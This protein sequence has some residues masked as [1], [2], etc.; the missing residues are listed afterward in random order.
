M[1]QVV[2]VVRTEPAY[3]KDPPFDPSEGYPE[4]S[5]LSVSSSRNVVFEAVRD[6]LRLAG[7]DEDRFGAADW[8]PLGE[9]I[10]PG[11]TVLLK[12]NWVHHSHPRDPE[13]WV[14]TITHGS[15][16]RAVAEYVAKALAGSGRIIVGDAPQTDASFSAIVE[17]TGVGRVAELF[18]T[19]GVRFDVIDFRREQWTESGGVIVKREPLAGDPEGCVKFDL[20]GASRF[21]GHGGAGRYYGA[22]YETDELNQHHSGGR[23]EYLVTGTA[24]SCDVF[25]NLPKLKT[26]KKTGVT[27]SLKNLVGINGDKNWLPH[28]TEGTPRTGGDQFPSDSMIRRIERLALRPLRKIAARLPW[29]GPR[30][31][32]AARRAGAKVAGDTES[33]VRS[34]NWSGNDTAWRMVLDLNAALLYGQPEGVLSRTGERK[35]YLSFVDGVIAGEGAG[36][37]NPDAKAVGLV[38]FG[39]TAAAVDSVCAWLMGFDP[40]RI[41]VL[42]EAYASTAFP[43]AAG[44]WRDI[45][46]VSNVSSWCSPLSE[47]PAVSCMGFLP[48]FGWVGAIERKL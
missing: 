32:G 17:K 8:N 3:P 18:Q 23:H 7:L 5:G 1:N 21:V 11:Q 14:Y 25:I 48:H 26:H 9:Y 12:P 28:H 13:G 33:V 46:V 30:L 10:R 20:G 2:A 45:S 41:P 36:P 34:G 24:V 44:N 19:R 16:I 29:V 27:I 39:T 42:R 22:F 15:V 47:I 40:D 35:P 4:L 43:I 38:A 37:L 31:L 6:S